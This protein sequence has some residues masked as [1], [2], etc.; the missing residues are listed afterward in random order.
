MAAFEFGNYQSSSSRGAS[1]QLPC[2]QNSHSHDPPAR[3]IQEP[4]LTMKIY[5]SC[6]NKDCLTGSELGPSRS[7]EGRPIEAPQ[8]AH[9]VS[10]EHLRVSS[11]VVM[12][13]EPSP[14]KS[15]F[16]NI[17]LQYNFEYCLKFYGTDGHPIG[18]EVPA[19]NYFTRKVTL[20]GSHAHEISLFTDLLGNPNTLIDGGAPNLMVEAK[21]MALTAEIKRRRHSHC[22]EHGHGEG[23]EEG[24]EGHHHH[25]HGRVFVTIGLFSIIKLYRLVSLLVES[26]GFVIPPPCKNIMPTNPCDFFDDLSFPMDDFAPRQKREFLDGTSINIPSEPKK[27]DICHT[28]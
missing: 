14:F 12:R 13:K 21:A 10:V 24:P 3:V 26:R 28:C 23:H 1:S 11:I 17:E 22:H 25:H 16:W 8:E 4:I 6:R 27:G 7:L 20:F 15:G 18:C 5:D 9:S 2:A 19:T